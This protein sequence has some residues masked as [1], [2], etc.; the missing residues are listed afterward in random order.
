[1]KYSDK[2]IRKIED[3]YAEFGLDETSAIDKAIEIGGILSDQKLKLGP[4][5]F[6]TWTGY[7]PFTASEVEKFIMIY[8]NR[9]ELAAKAN[10][11]RKIKSSGTE[12]SSAS[13]Q[14]SIREAFER[15][16]R[17]RIKSGPQSPGDISIED[18]CRRQ[19]KSGF[20]PGDNVIHA[21]VERCLSEYAGQE[22]ASI[23]QSLKSGNITHFDL[24]EITLD[25]VSKSA[26]VASSEGRNH[27]QVNCMG[28]FLSATCK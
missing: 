25:V 14:G 24:Y 10:K 17:E 15:D 22:K 12:S 2:Q 13:T 9:A 20:Y 6:K 7:L 23:E 8:E 19:L 1:M 3:A 27:S 18:L 21:A 16:W 4:H 26:A 28:S 5:S 11:S